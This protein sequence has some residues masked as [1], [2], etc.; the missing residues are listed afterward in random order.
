LIADGQLRASASFASNG[1]KANHARFSIVVTSYNQLTF[2]ATAVES[3]LNQSFRPAEV[4]IVDDGSNDGSAEL[5]K[6]YDKTARVVLSSTNEGA[7]AA[8]NHGAA[9]ARGD[10]VVFLDGDDVLLP[11][12][13]QVYDRLITKLHPVMIVGQRKWFQDDVPVLDLP[14]E[15]EYVEYDAPLSKDRSV[16]LGASS[17]VVQRR[18]FEHV[19]MWT[20]GIFHLDLQDLYMKLGEAGTM[21]LI[22]TPATAGYRIHASNT[23]HSVPPF[24][25]SLFKLLDK[26]RTEQYGSGTEYRMARRAWLGGLSAFWIRRAFAAGLFWQAV[27]LG[28][29]SIP[30]MTAALIC[31]TAARLRGRQPIQKLALHDN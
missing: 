8:R 6:R 19:G 9:M 17:L 23:I 15:V 26:E 13:L 5:L 27:K 7:I 24:L 22:T 3:A 28:T 20:P 25:R 4:I 30:L 29:R 1:T 16:G 14:R 2:I 12:A 11:W 21:A 18:A 31:R 10:Y